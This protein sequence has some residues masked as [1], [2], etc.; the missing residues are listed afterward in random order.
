[1]EPLMPA[2]TRPIDSICLADDPNVTVARVE[3]GLTLYLTD[4]MTW[5][6]SGAARALE[7]FLKRAPRKWLTFYTTS[8]LPRWH[9]IGEA[10]HAELV[11]SLSLPWSAGKPRHLL[12]FEL[13]D[14]MHAH[15]AG[16]AY[17]EIDP[18]RTGRAG[19]LELTLPQETDPAQ[20]LELTQ[21]VAA[22]GPFFCGVAGYVARWNVNQRRLAFEHIY[23]WSH[24]YWGL[25]AQDAERFSWLA[26]HALPGSNWLTLI[27]HGLLD[28]AKLDLKPLLKGEG[29]H[30]VEATSLEQGVLVR[31]GKATI[32]DL[33]EV[34][35]PEAYAEAARWLAPA[36]VKE[37]PPL[38]GPFADAENTLDWQQRFLVP[39]KWS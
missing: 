13:S 9:V 5:A 30:D 2:L 17:R 4:M 20:L 15:C 14:D 18:T 21:E 19:I 28:A 12:S 8:L 23:N 31:A 26:P 37:P 35:V 3:L 24:R 32:G 11:S 7:L 16:F 27:G 38:Y 22:C 1:V 36:F 34:T 39:K 33:N 25:D 10:S 29:L 6:R